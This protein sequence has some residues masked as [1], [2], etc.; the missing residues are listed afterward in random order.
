MLAMSVGFAVITMASLMEEFF[1]EL[2]HYPMIEAH[3]IENLVVAAGLLI[4]V[5]SIY[6]ARG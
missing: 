3:I 1:L 6:V 4:I 2:L 5:Y